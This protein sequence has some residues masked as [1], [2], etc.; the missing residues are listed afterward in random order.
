MPNVCPESSGS[1]L[2]SVLWFGEGGNHSL[3][4]VGPPGVGRGCFPESK[5]FF[6]ASS[7]S[8][9]WDCFAKGHK[10]SSTAHM[11]GQAPGGRAASGCQIS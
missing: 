9:L 1:S 11:A 8:Q 3:L 7:S 10:S 4:A 2:G 5:L 6:V